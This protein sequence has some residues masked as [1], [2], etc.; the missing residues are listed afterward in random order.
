MAA[1]ANIASSDASAVNLKSSE[2]ESGPA[3]L[4]NGRTS[5]DGSGATV[6]LVQPVVAQQE[7]AAGDEDMVQPHLPRFRESAGGDSRRRPGLDARADGEAKLVH[8]IGFEQRAEQPRA[9]FAQDLPQ[10]TLREFTQHETGVEPR[11]PANEDVGD[12]GERLSRSEERR[13]GKECTSRGAP[14]G[15]LSKENGRAGE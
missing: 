5:T 4:A 3:S 14:A 12:A 1:S 7:G 2:I 6:L 15:E 9:A 13:V 11:V 8:A 10:A